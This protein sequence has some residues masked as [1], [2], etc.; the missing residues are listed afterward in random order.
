M[1]IGGGAGGGQMA[2][3]RPRV[4]KYPFSLLNLPKEKNIERQFNV[5][6]RGFYTLLQM[7]P[8]DPLST[9]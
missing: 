5:E 9:R 6:K 1:Y 2:N 7:P 8:P 3:I 4:V